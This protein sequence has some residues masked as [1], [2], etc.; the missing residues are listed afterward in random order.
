MARFPCSRCGQRYSGPQQTAYPSVV[1]P[2]VTYS[3]RLRLCPA[4]FLAVITRPEW[5]LSD[6]ADEEVITECG[7]CKKAS[8]TIPL[9]CTYYELRQERQDLYGRIHGGDCLTDFLE[10]VWGSL[11]AAQ[12]AFR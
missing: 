10:A 4:C 8:P 7:V 2:G 12:V 6:P 1:T 5:S 11:D 9:F 3:E